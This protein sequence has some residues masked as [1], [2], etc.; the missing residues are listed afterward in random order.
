MLFDEQSINP[1]IHILRRSQ[2]LPLIG[3]AHGNGRPLSAKR[4][5]RHLHML[6]DGVS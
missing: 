6:P 1:A 5:L 2:K 4:N 3:I